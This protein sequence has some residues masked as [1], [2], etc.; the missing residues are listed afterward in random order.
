MINRIRFSDRIW[1]G[2]EHLIIREQDHAV[3][4]TKNNNRA[5]EEICTVPNSELHIG[6]MNI[7]Q[8]TIL[9]VLKGQLD[10]N[11]Y[12]TLITLEEALVSLKAECLIVDMTDVSTLTNSGLVALNNLIR[13]MNGKASTD[14]DQ[15]WKAL[16]DMEKDFQAGLQTHVKI[17]SPQ[18]KVFELLTK[19]GLTQICEV[20]N[21]LDTALK[22]LGWIAKD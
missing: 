16:H 19:S 3:Q 5:S 22:P 9:L 15:G 10:R 21:D 11:T 18:Y 12:E 20:F 1:Q 14:I 6:Y 4:S 7:D 8:N 17:L 13:L 2:F